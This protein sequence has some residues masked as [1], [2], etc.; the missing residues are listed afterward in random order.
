MGNEEVLMKI[1]LW[2]FGASVIFAATCLA[3]DIPSKLE[4]FP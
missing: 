1:K 3:Q 4:I 2:C